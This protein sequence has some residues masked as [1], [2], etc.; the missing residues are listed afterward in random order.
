MTSSRTVTNICN[1]ALD[2][3]KEAPMTD[4]DTDATPVSRWFLRNYAEQRDALLRAY[5]WRFAIKRKRL[6]PL[7][8]VLRG[9]STTPVLSGAWGLFRLT[10]DWSGYLARIRRSSDSTT[11]DV[12]AAEDVL[13]IDVDAIETFV[14]SGGTGYIDRL[15][16][17][18]GNGRSLLQATT[19][20]QPAFDGEEDESGIP[21]ASFDGTDDLLATSGAM[22]N[23]ISTT[24]GY[25]VVAGLIDTVTL[26]SAT[27][28]SNHLLLGDASAKIG[29]YA[30]LGGT[31][32]G[33]NDDGS[34]DS[35]KH[36]FPP[37]VP[38]VAELRHL[39]GTLYTRVNGENE[40]SGTS[41]T[42]SSLA[43][44]FN[45]GDIAG[46]NA[47]DFKLFAVLI[48]STAPTEAERNR[49]VDR[50]MRHVSA[51]GRGEVGWDWRY[52]IPDDCL[53]MLPLRTDGEWD[54]T[55]IPHEIEEDYILTDRSTYVDSRYIRQMTDPTKY[56]A[57]FVQAFA[58][59]L[60]M[61]GAHRFTGKQSMIE[62]AKRDYDRAIFEARRANA[63][64]GTPEPAYDD[65]VI[66]ARYA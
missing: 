52:P 26:D 18:S 43:G 23:L 22:S 55:P 58:A 49:I 2:I 20:M 1:L 66:A 11:S 37:A 46:S 48:F 5:P 3:L 32:Y 54:G 36:A 16:D 63:F 19:T 60:A 59:S 21:A 4:V 61:K 39:S 8:Y 44:V 50:L 53:R 24:A 42:T 41:G 15:Y 12:S 28:A 29:L 17:Q 7:D 56:D 64:E 62:A 33:Y 34:S 30:R 25:I 10:E 51:G 40:K 6:Y 9:M 45:V 57:L 13:A 65:D 38:F 27:I 14:G 31:L 35:V 47:L